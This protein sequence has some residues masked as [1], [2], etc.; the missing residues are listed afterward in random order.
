MCLKQCCQP[1]R[2]AKEKKI[3]HATTHWSML[4]ITCLCIG[5]VSG[6]CASFHATKECERHNFCFE[7][8]EEIHMRLLDALFQSLNVEAT[9]VSQAPSKL[10]SSI[11]PNFEDVA[12]KQ[13]RKFV[14]IDLSEDSK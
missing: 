1:W 13:G 6:T 8:D 3:G 2:G 7:V 10:S 9:N 11:G 5:F 12:P 14:A 4:Y